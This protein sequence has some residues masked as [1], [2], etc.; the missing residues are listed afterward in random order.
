MEKN[1]KNKRDKIIAVAACSIITLIVLIIVVIT[2]TR[3]SV[4]SKPLTPYRTPRV[5]LNKT[6]IQT[7]REQP[8]T[9]RQTPPAYSEPLKN[10]GAFD[11]SNK[12]P[13]PTNC[14]Q[15]RFT[16][17]ILVDLTNRKIIWGHNETQQLP[18]ASISKLMTIYTAFEEMKNHPEIKLTTLV[19]VSRECT[20]QA[21]VKA[22]LVPGDKIA[23]NDVFKYSMLKSANDAA[24]LIAE[25]FGYGDAQ[26]FIR[27][28]NS[29]AQELGMTSSKFINANGLPIYTENSQH[30][31]K[32][33]K[34]SC[35]DLILLME[36]I[37]ENK[38]IMRYTQTEKTRIRGQEITNGNKLLGSVRGM[39]G[40]K[41]G[42]TNA[43]G[44]CLAFSCERNG[45]VLIGVILGC[46]SNNE[47][48][49]LVRKL[50]EWGF[51]N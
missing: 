22:P 2:A 16:A 8:Q 31:A 12:K 40:M 30:N 20:L 34:S 38:A 28:M 51:N 46:K 5:D 17:G 33:N 44:H 19:T 32:M 50:L 21:P 4:Q 15:H 11:S 10:Y 39:T 25:Y 35:M 18:I 41:T 47:R 45:R 9:N 48:S 26:N 23:L 7:H 13:L 36:R 3:N 43:A 49:E 1:L 29:K 24:Y 27:I 37:A 6:T 42:Y 14:R